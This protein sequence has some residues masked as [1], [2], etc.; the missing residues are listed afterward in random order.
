QVALQ[1]LD[2]ERRRR[3]TDLARR[4]RNSRIRENVPE[5]FVLTA[6]LSNVDNATKVQ[7]GRR[8]VRGAFNHEEPGDRRS[9]NSSTQK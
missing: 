6:P 1:P 9:I 7:D 8:K 2:R 4:I 3:C 5:H